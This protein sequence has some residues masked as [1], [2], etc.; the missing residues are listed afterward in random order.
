LPG[1][2]YREGGSDE[3]DSNTTHAVAVTNDDPRV[4]GDDRIRPEGIP[5]FAGMTEPVE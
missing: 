1:N 5:A 2:G 3:V 4:R